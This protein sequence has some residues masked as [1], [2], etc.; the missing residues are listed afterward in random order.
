MFQQRTFKFLAAFIGVLALLLLP[1][2][3]WPGYLDTPMGTIVA[4]PYLSIYLFHKLGIPGLLQNDGLCGWGWCAPTSFG[5]VFLCS[6]WLLVMW[7]MAWLAAN[8]ASRPLDETT[9]DDTPR[10]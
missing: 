5:W 2:L 9:N 4:I 8:L 1:A 10:R 7:L 6:F 3:R